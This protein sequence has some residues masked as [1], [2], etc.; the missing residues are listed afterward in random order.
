MNPSM[1]STTSKFTVF[2]YIYIVWAKLKENPI[3]SFI[4]NEQNA[5]NHL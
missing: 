4:C 1:L 5:L 3:N 2:I